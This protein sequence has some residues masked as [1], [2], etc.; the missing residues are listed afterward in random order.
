[1]FEKMN[2]RSGPPNNVQKYINHPTPVNAPPE[3]R[4]REMLAHRK[5]ICVYDDFYQNAKV[6]HFMGDNASGARLLV[7]FYAFLFFEDWKQDLWTKR[8]VRDHLRYID[9]IQ[10][11]AAKI[12]HAVRE[13]AKE[14]GDPYGQ[15]DSMHVRRG[16]FQYKQTRI[17]ADE[18]YENIND[19]VKEKNTLF[20]AT[21][22]KNTTFFKPLMDHYNVYFLK[23]FLH[24]I[25][26]LN[27]NY[28]GMLD[29]LIASRGETFSGA[30]YSTFTGYIHR[31]RGYHSQKS[32]ALGWKE[33][34]LKSY[35]YVE[36][37][38]KDELINYYPLKGPLWGQR[39]SC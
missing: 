13:K 25:P 11:A 14:N 2:V 31:I 17:E 36:K 16:D 1:M 35:Y 29:Q 18:I 37:K 8:Y 21:D 23:D 19:I 9:E 34:K 3:D 6:M 15:F 32:K 20:I 28:Y 4:L 38:H 10:C 33:G 30:Y 5:E 27:K 7:H 22:E 39:I 24:L 12:V 26:S